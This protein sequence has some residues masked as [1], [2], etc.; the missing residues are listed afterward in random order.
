MGAASRTRSGTSTRESSRMTLIYIHCLG[1]SACAA[2][3]PCS[4]SPGS[5]ANIKHN[6][7]IKS[8]SSM[9]DFA[10]PLQAFHI[11]DSHV[12]V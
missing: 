7:D 8:D 5:Q 9:K 3:S 1:P 4:T 6:R 12:S 10:L 11:H 2:E